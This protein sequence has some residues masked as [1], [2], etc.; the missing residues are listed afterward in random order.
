MTGEEKRE[1]E[2]AIDEGEGEKKRAGNDRCD[3]LWY[4][5]SEGG[6]IESEG[7]GQGGGGRE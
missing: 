7:E 5:G 6:R 4:E 2:R 3:G 1:K